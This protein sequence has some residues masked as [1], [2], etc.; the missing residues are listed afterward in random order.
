MGIER[1][2]SL[3]I[4]TQSTYD[5]GT[6]TSLLFTRKLR[7]NSLVINMNK[8]TINPHFY[9]T[10]ET[11]R[12]FN[13]TGPIDPDN[14]RRPKLADELIEADVFIYNKHRN[15][16][17]ISRNNDAEAGADN[18]SDLEQFHANAPKCRPRRQIIP[19]P[20]S[21]SYSEYATK[22]AEC[23]PRL[24]ANVDTDH[25]QALLRDTDGSR[26]VYHSDY[27]RPED[28]IVSQ[29]T[30]RRQAERDGALPPS[31]RIDT[32]YQSSWRSSDQIRTI[33]AI[34]P[35]TSCRPVVRDAA[36]KAQLRKIFSFG[37][38][39]YRHRVC[40]LADLSLELG[41]YG[42]VPQRSGYVDRYTKDVDTN[43]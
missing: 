35:T 9:T 18:F 5:Y 36:L 4:S 7:I 22:L 2:T 1:Y 39:E 25:L 42:P 24:F 41:K 12:Q 26:S 19:L 43:V 40:D 3:P 23:Y 27:C 6:F 28:G 37:T 13:N 21:V 38:T 31:W 15:N 20:Q 8:I 29:T 11:G 14:L 17:H 10:T 16:L 32:T 30:L 34:L 33:G